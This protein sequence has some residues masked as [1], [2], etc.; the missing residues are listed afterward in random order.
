MVSFNGKDHLLR[1]PECAGCVVESDWYKYKA[2]KTVKGRECR[3]IFIY[4][5]NLELQ[6]S[7]ISGQLWKDG[8]LA[9]RVYKFVRVWCQVKVPL[10]YCI[11]VTLV[12]AKLESSILLGHE[13]YQCGQFHLCEVNDILG[14]E[15]IISRSFSA[16]VFSNVLGKGPSILELSP[17]VIAR[18]GVLQLW[19]AKGEPPLSIRSATACQLKAVRK[20]GNV[21]VFRHHISIH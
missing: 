14:E 21:C 16:H 5:M 6:I 11:T 12:E 18:C 7:V 13:Y 3:L 17:I 19:C 8:R 2:I 9:K 10:I 4:I 1:T 20:P 15:L